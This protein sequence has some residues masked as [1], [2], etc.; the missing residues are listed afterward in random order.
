MRPSNAPAKGAFGLGTSTVQVTRIKK[1]VRGAGREL[2]PGMGEPIDIF[3][4]K[5]RIARR[6]VVL[7]G[8]DRDR[9]QSD[10]F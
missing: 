2:A 5:R 7:V 1:L 4:N 8:T 3:A 6:E 10:G 9:N